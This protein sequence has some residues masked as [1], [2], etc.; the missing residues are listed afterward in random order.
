[1]GVYSFDVPGPGDGSGRSIQKIMGIIFVL[2]KRVSAF[3]LAAVYFYGNGFLYCRQGDLKDKII[4]FL[5]LA[6]QLQLLYPECRE[7]ELETYFLVPGIAFGL[8]WVIG[9][10]V[11]HRVANMSFL[12]LDIWGI[13]LVRRLFQKQ[14]TAMRICGHMPAYLLLAVLGARKQRI[15]ILWR[16]LAAIPGFIWIP[17]GGADPTSPGRSTAK[18]RF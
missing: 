4:T 6:V 15:R 11:G 12:M 7:E 8:V 1:M 17:R 5:L 14:R 18:K 2:Y 9:S 16:C 3:Y 13:H 10:N